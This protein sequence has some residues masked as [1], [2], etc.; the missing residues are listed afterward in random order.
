MISWWFTNITLHCFV[1]LHV[2]LSTKHLRATLQNNILI[3]LILHN[4]KPRVFT[5][6][7]F[8]S[9]V[10]FLPQAEP[11]WPWRPKNR[12]WPSPAFLQS[13]SWLWREDPCPSIC[14]RVLSKLNSNLLSQPEGATCVM[15]RSR[16][17]S[18]WWT[19]QK[20]VQSVKVLLTCKCSE[21]K[22][23]GSETLC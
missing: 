11:F 20:K 12:M 4:M 18:C 13:C 22:A 15:S 6:H 1:V 21:N 16:G 5:P 19:R 17:Q 7:R 9:N 3:M 2:K 14:D 23:F 8:L 10:P